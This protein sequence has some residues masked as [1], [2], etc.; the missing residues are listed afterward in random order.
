[1]VCSPSR[2][3]QVS[4]VTPS[5]VERL[6]PQFNMLRRKSTSSTIKRFNKRINLQTVPRTSG[7]LKPFQTS[8][9][10]SNESFPYLS[11]SL[12]RLNQANAP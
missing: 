10:L 12:R 1:M 6:P 11:S 9:E 7:N 3:R 2:E 4:F 5:G 8:S